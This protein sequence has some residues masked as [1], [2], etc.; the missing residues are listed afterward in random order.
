MTNAR[1]IANDIGCCYPSSHCDIYFE[2][3]IDHNDILTELIQLVLDA[4][5]LLEPRE[6]VDAEAWHDRFEGFFNNKIK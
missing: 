6:D 5:I 4:R 2:K 1:N 3:G